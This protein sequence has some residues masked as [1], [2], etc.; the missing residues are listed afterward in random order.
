MFLRSLSTILIALGIALVVSGFV[1]PRLFPTMFVTEEM[2]NEYTEAATAY[3]NATSEGPEIRRASRVEAARKRFE[4]VRTQ[5]ETGQ[6]RQD[7]TGWVLTTSG[8]SLLLM[9]AL[10]RRAYPSRQG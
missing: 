4:K 10:L 2:A 8:F 6:S 3:H 7:S 5:V 1:V 9:G